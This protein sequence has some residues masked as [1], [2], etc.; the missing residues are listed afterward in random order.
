MMT[1][2]QAIEEMNYHNDPRVQAHERGRVEGFDEKAMTITHVIEE[3][4][5]DKCATKGPPFYALDARYFHTPGGWYNPDATGYYVIDNRDGS[6]HSVFHMKEGPLPYWNY[7][8]EGRRDDHEMNGRDEAE[9]C[10]NEL[11]AALGFPADWQPEPHVIVFRARYEV[12]DLCDGKGTHV[13][14]DIDCGGIS[15]DDPF[16][17]D[18]IDYDDDDG[19]TSRYMRGDY[20]VACYACKGKRVVP[21]VA[22]DNNADDL[23]LW[24]KK[25]RDDAAYAAECAAERRMGA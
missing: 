18:D 7:R 14:P 17:E 25:Q 12:C 2:R 11:N 9:D 3:C 23:K 1:S 4:G 6:V 8:D 5:C 15:S 24:H 16:W 13:N 10:A 21:V 22:E 19:P 20:D